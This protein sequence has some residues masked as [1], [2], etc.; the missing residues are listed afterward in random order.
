MSWSNTQ[1][2]LALEPQS[3]KAYVVAEG[4][5]LRFGSRPGV[6]VAKRLLL[7]SGPRVLMVVGATLG[8]TLGGA[9]LSW[10]LTGAP[11]PPASLLIAGQN[12]AAKASE[13]EGKARLTQLDHATRTSPLMHE[14]REG[15]T[16]Q[17]LAARY[18]L[19]ARTLR[20]ANLMDR[21]ARL[22][23]GTKLMVPPV[24]GLAHLVKAPLSLGQ[25]AS[26]YG[27][28]PTALQALN[29][30]LAAELQAGDRVFIPGAT[31][32]VAEQVAVAPV[33]PAAPVQAAPVAPR[34]AA[35]PANVRGAY[36]PRDR[37]SRLIA[38]RSLIGQFG[39]RVGSLLWPAS[40]QLSSPFGLRG[41]GFHPG[42][43]ICNRVGTPIHAAKP[44]TVVASGWNAG[45]G[46]AIDIDHGNGV[47]T[48]YGHCSALLVKVGQTVQAG[49]RI[50][51]MGSTGYSTG[52]HV[53]FEVR[54]QGRPVNPA[55]FF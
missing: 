31:A 52:P 37:Q 34:A 55:T 53:H 22:S 23:P 14:V 40:G 3:L 36:R 20:L 27:V 10:A 26:R 8:V 38:S 16:F 6:A 7:T 42:M 9:G 5:G 28:S 24:E 45:Y 11:T 32:L 35:A 49:E 39:G 51:L 1:A 13:Q 30:N 19:S 25:L 43:D 2:P 50:G 15:D 12:A 33:A 47:V 18:R 29:P 17:G 41:A 4:P 44:G 46:N 21:N 48:R 54:I